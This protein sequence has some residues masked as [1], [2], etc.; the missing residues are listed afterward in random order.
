MEYGFVGIRCAAA[1]HAGL[2]HLSNSS[3]LSYLDSKRSADATHV[4][5]GIGRLQLRWGREYAARH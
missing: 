3:L 1:I 5:G 2:S 4:R